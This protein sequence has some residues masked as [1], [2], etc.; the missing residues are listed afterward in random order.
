MPARC[1][2]E[3]H[4]LPRLWTANGGF[5]RTTCG[6]AA[7][8]RQ[9]GTATVRASIGAG[10]AGRRGRESGDAGGPGCCKRST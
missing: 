4:N 1:W 2:R 6:L 8:G 7:A 5:G 9:A 10:G 3:Q